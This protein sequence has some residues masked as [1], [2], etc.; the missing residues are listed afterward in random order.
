M[1]PQ[2]V[3]AGMTGLLL[4]AAAPTHGAVTLYGVLDL[5]ARQV[6]NS[7]LSSVTSMVSGSSATSRVGVRGVEDLGG[8]LS[9]GF[10]LEHG[11]TADT[12]TPSGGTRFWDRRSTVSLISR[13]FGELRLG[14]DF[15]P[16][17]RNWSRYDPFAYVGVARSADLLSNTPVGP[18]N[19]AFARNDNTTVRADNAVQYL[20]PRMGGIEGELMVAPGEGGDVTAGRAKLIGM[21]LGYATKTYGVSAA[22]S[23]SENSRTTA[24]KFKDSAIGAQVRLGHVELSAA[25]RQLKYDAVKQTNVLLG[26]VARYGLHVIKA[27]YNRVDMEGS[28][29]TTQVAAND[30]DKWGLGYAYNLS[31]RTGWYASLARISNDGGAR[32]SIPGGASGLAGG[33]SS[34]GYEAGLIHRF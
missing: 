12:G 16:T 8:G 26:V 34:T 20:L 33:G 4:T 32:Y 27:S 25:W 15:V 21:R 18:I 28:V 2:I 30:A 10:N 11:F 9:A 23:T 13:R 22:T 31:K 19:A 24:G 29:G 1:K 17:Y 5:A 6:S 14:R 7:G 3:A